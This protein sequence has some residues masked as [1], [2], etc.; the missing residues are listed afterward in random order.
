VLFLGKRQQSIVRWGGPDVPSKVPRRVQATQLQPTRTVLLHSV[1][2]R[3]FLFS[4]G[5]RRSP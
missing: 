2:H 4:R 1:A 3:H 5:G